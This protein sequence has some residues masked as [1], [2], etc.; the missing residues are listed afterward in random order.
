[1]FR[2][3]IGD[4]ILYD[5]IP[6]DV[7][8]ILIGLIQLVEKARKLSTNISQ[9]EGTEAGF[10]DNNN[11][12]NNDGKDNVDDVTYSSSDVTVVT[13]AAAVSDFVIQIET[14]FGL[15][16]IPVPR[17]KRREKLVTMEVK[18]HLNTVVE[19]NTVWGLVEVPQ[20]SNYEEEGEK[21]EELNLRASEEVE[22]N[23]AST[24]QK[25]LTLTATGCGDTNSAHETLNWLRDLLEEEWKVE[26][27]RLV[28]DGREVLHA[29][30]SYALLSSRGVTLVCLPSENLTWFNAVRER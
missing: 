8:E 2:T 12:N 14:L 23:N 9:G 30:V 20:P 21:E 17:D 26:W 7:R 19:R 24:Q 13:T 4:D 25:K 1:M 22:S 11:N 27:R 15:S 18:K 3:Q 29:A 28:T 5:Q 6:V 16:S 10:A